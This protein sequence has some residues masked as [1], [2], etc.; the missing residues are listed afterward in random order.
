MDQIVLKLEGLEMALN[1]LV[2][3][4]ASIGVNV[5]RA[6]FRIGGLWKRTAVEYAP[7]SPSTTMLKTFKKKMAGGGEF[8]NTL[9]VVGRKGSSGRVIKMTRFYEAKMDML[10]SKK[11]NNTNKPMPG[12]LMRSITVRSTEHMVEVFVPSNSPAGSYAFKMHEEKGSRWKERG[13]GTQAKGPK[14][15]DKFITRAAT[16][17]KGEFIAIINDELNKAID[18][19]GK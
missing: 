17:K 7:I 15:D 8:A 18:K 11:P 13:P 10:L 19:G 4:N 5:G 6:L 16:D 12:G 2:S 14:A 9:Y 3:V 1:K